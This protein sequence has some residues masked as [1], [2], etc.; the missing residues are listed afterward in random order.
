LALPSDP[1]YRVLASEFNFYHAA[2]ADS[3]STEPG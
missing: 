2:K 3:R 1:S